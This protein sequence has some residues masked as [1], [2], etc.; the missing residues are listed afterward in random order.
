MHGGGP[1]RGAKKIALYPPEP[2]PWAE[3]SGRRKIGGETHVRAGGPE[4][5]AASCGEGSCSG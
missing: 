4:P 3:G 1:R 5:P 2:G